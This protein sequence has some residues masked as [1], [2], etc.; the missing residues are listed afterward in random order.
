MTLFSAKSAEIKTLRR[1][2]QWG[3]RDTRRKGM[4]ADREC[5]GQNRGKECITK[6]G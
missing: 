1:E 2:E 3:S 5:E 6:E 4:G